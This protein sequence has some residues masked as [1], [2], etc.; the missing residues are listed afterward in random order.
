MLSKS[1]QMQRLAPARA[2][3]ALALRSRSA[4][5]VPL[6]APACRVVLTRRCS[7]S[8][9]PASTT[10]A[11]RDEGKSDLYYVAWGAAFLFVFGVPMYLVY[12]LKEDTEVRLLLGEH[13][14]ALVEAVQG[15]IDIDEARRDDAYFHVDRCSAGE[16]RP[17]LAARLVC[18][19]PHCACETQRKR[20]NS[21]PR[22]AACT[23]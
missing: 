16:L 5:G 4:L 10:A 3:L 21:R 18:R 20:C 6:Q 15:F 1:R 23:R 9:T 8:S 13:A 12:L 7:S 11:A 14:P 22:M 2:R 17:P 19:H